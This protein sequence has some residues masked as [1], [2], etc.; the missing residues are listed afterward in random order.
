MNWF[1]GKS[2]DDAT[3]DLCGS[4]GTLGGPLAAAPAGSGG[5]VINGASAGAGHVSIGGGSGSAGGSA[6]GGDE[7]AG[8]IGGG[9]MST[10]ERLR[11]PSMYVK[12]QARLQ[13]ASR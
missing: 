10:M 8:L 9:G 1:T 12:N 7:D 4:S 2:V 3:S 5:S 6:G 11:K 13:K